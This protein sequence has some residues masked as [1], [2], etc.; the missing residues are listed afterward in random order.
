M[1]QRFFLAVALCGGLLVGSALRAQEQTAAQP[2]A[3][4]HK[5]AKGMLKI[6]TALSGVFESTEMTEVALRPEEWTAFEVVEVVEPGTM[7]EAGDTLIR[8]D[9]EDYDEAL[10]EMERARELAYLSLRSDEEELRFLEQTTPLDLA[11][12][13][14]TKLVADDE[15]KHFLDVGLSLLV[16]NTEYSLKN[17][18]FNVEYSEEELKQ[19]EQMYAADDLTEESEE[20]ILLRSRRDVEAA[21]FFLESAQDNYQRG[22]DVLIP[23]QQVDL[24]EG[25]TRAG[26]R[27]DEARAT[28]PMALSLKRLQVEEA[29]RA[30][31]KSDEQFARLQQD[32]SWLSFTAPT[33]GIVYY[34]QCVRGAWSSAAVAASLKPEGTVQPKQVL[35]TVVKPRPLFVRA[36]LPE[37]SLHLVRAGIAGRATPTAWPDV[38]VPVA[39]EQ[40]SLLPVAD[41]SYDVRLAAEA[42]DN[43]TAVLPGM[44]AS[45]KLTSYRNP[46]AL[47]VPEAAVF[48]EEEDDS[49]RYVYLV[50]GEGQHEQR[51][52]AV[53]RS[54][55][56]RI[57]ITGGL[58][59]GQEILASKPSRP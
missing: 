13:E 44:A 35:M 41:G 11:A 25:A 38:R 22:V 1:S 47:T 2:A 9:S 29:R 46:D 50:T 39:V 51:V 52:V 57:E 34:G 56:G 59:E 17:S 33:D 40:V 37:A 15:L 7:V 58:D 36:S 5:V 23:R 3:T 30:R 32:R 14:R 16:R 21:R 12:A 19:L 49:V 28:L 18:Q 42:G 55:E 24:T 54:S 8:F 48:A 4:T 43:A 31:Q 26:I 10:L 27:L 53:G 45:V 20:I 6:E